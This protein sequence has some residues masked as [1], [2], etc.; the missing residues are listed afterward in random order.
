VTIEKVV[1]RFSS[2]AEVNAADIEDYRLLSP[3]QRVASLFEMV[4]RS[5]KVEKVVQRVTLAEMKDE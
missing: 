5:F 3:A 2:F 4:G 1:R